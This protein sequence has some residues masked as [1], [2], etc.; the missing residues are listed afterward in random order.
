MAAMASLIT[1][2]LLSDGV[3]VTDV[4]P[5]LAPVVPVYVKVQFEPFPSVVVQLLTPGEG[6]TETA[7]IPY[8]VLLDKVHVDC[9]MPALQTHAEQLK[10]GVLVIFP[11]S[12]TVR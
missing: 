3:E 11:S 4:L 5:A 7:E 9:A 6:E 12:G 8:P 1:T 10:S 2:T